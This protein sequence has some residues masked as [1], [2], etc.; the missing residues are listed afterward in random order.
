MQEKT[1]AEKAFEDYLRKK[2][3]SEISDSG[4]PSTVYDYPARVKRICKR[5]GFQHLDELAWHINDIVQKY[6][7]GGEHAEYG[8]QSNGSTR[9]A[10]KLFR[11]FIILIS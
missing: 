8:A 5:E 11:E 2:G 1:I 7:K 3:A 10:L 6:D 9:K 4:N